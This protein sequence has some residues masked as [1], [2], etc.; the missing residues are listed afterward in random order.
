MKKIVM[1]LLAGVLSV[2]AFVTPVCAKTTSKAVNVSKMQKSIGECTVSGKN[3]YYVKTTYK[4][5]VATTTLYKCTL[6]GT[7]SVQVKKLSGNYTVGAVYNKKIYVSKGNE[8]DG[9]KTYAITN[10]GKGKMQLV[11]KNLKIYTGKGRYLVGISSE[12]TDVGPKQ[13]CVYDAKVNKKQSLGEGYCPTIIGNKV[14]YASWNSK[15][16]YYELA[17]KV[18]GTTNKVIVAKF[19]KAPVVVVNTI[20]KNQATYYI[21]SNNTVKT[22][23][24]RY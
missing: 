3:V 15:Q 23:I 5:D 8:M 9:Y 10:L 2:G 6:K 21:D 7:K 20:S 4:K 22:K 1:L 12:P 11:K 19:P 14:Y 24:L 16:N 17:Y 18:L 13:L